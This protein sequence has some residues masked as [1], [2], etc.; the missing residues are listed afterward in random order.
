[1]TLAARLVGEQDVLAAY[2]LSSFPFAGAVAALFVIVVARAQA[3][4]WV[5]RGLAAGA[6]RTRL[7]RLEERPGFVRAI[8]LL[9]RWGPIAVTLC[10]FTVGI[11]TMVNA[12]A[13]VIAMPWVRYTLFMLPGAVA[14]AFIYATVGLAAFLALAAAWSG[15]WWARIAILAVLSAAVAAVALRRRR[16]GAR[17]VQEPAEV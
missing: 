14:W 4:Y 5:G 3:T 17:R 10:F 7:Q 9:H 8:G 1:M 11:Q 2:G 12:A 6:R 16:S 13:G 15:S